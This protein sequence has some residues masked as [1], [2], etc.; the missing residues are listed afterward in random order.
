MLVVF[1]SVGLLHGSAAGATRRY[2]TGPL[3]YPLP[4]AGTTAVRLV[5]PDSGPISYLEVSLRIDHPR[6]S[7]LTL[8]LVSPA[9][10]PV[11]LTAKRGGKGRNYGSGAP[12]G[13][14]A[15]LFSSEGET[16]IARGKPPFTYDIFKS[17]QPLSRLYGEEA[18]GHWQLRITDDTPGAAGTLRCFKLLV[19]R[20]ILQTQTAR[21]RDTEAQLEFHE[22]TGTLTGLRLRIERGGRAIFDAPPKRLEACTCPDNGP[23]VQQ[24]GGALHVR[25]VD[26]D[27]EPEVVIDSYWGAPH[28]CFYT[29]VYRYVR[30]LDSYRP[31]IGF[32]GNVPSRLVDIGLDGRP[33]FKTADNRFAYAFTSFAGSAFPIQIFRFDHGRFVDVTSATGQRCG[34]T[35]PDSSRSTGRSGTS[36]RA[37][38]AGSSRR[39][40]PSSTS[41]AAARPAGPCSKGRCGAANSTPSRSRERTCAGCGPSCAGPATSGASHRSDL[42]RPVAEHGHALPAAR[43][44]GHGHVV[45]P[46]HE[47]DVDQALVDPV[48]ILLADRDRVGVA[49]REV[50]GGVLVEERV[51]EDGLEAADPPFAVDERELAQAGSALVHGDASA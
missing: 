41:S 36:P 32:W 28:C 20:D 42:P 50:A 35:R 29:D 3:S 22:R 25:D 9:G 5:V 46:D 14:G 1:L 13:Y 19:S 8:T 31:A 23:L 10:T 27:G 24:S 30:R 39:G 51:L 43:D 15:T 17:E 4:D 48:E 44:P 47:V 18:S 45:A 33:E 11:V 49:E 40:S 21:A 16:P 6:D 34:A 26:G 12:C 2:S 37:T 7:D 38:S